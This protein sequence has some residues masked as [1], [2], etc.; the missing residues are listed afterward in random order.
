[1]NPTETAQYW[2]KNCKILDTETTGLDD[3]AEIIEISAIDQDGTIL[4]DTLVKP[5]MP[6]PTEATKVHG[7]TNEMVADAPSWPEIHDEVISLFS[8][9]PVVIYNKDYD[10]RLINQTAA[11]HNLSSKY[12]CHDLYLSS[13]C[14]MLE[15][16]QF[17]G[18]WAEYKTQYK[19]QSLIKA[20]QQQ[21][22]E[23]D[24]QAHRAL[25]DCRMTL[26]VIK[27]MA[28]A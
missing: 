11:K 7:I 4:I 22:I 8:G 9:A 6:I 28:N 25:F 18:E 26:E 27:V 19:W 16:A 21:S 14:A 23:L 5:T 17:Y 13:H 10:L 24:G 20:A 15:Y 1:M 3:K 2:L 12:L